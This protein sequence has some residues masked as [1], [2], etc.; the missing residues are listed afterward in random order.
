MAFSA[1]FGPPWYRDVRGHILRFETG[2]IGVPVEYLGMGVWRVVVVGGDN[3]TY[4]HGGYD[5]D[6]THTDIDGAA[7]VEIPA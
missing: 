2:V 1:L 3:P 7:R 6:V 5:I 4:P